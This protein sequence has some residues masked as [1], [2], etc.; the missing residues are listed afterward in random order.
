[1]RVGTG[2]TVSQIIR[3]LLVENQTIVRA[4]LRLILESQAGLNVVAEASTGAEAVAAAEQSQPDVVLLDLDTDGEIGYNC[5]IE[6][7]RA[8]PQTRVLV[9]TGVED[10]EIHYEAIYNGA[11]GLVHKLEQADVLLR[12]IRKVYADEVWLDGAMMARLLQ[13]LRRV[14][15]IQQTT[16]DQPAELWNNGNGHEKPPRHGREDQPRS[17]SPQTTPEEAVKIAQLTDRE[18]EV[19]ALVGEGLRNQQI[20]DRLFISVITVRH[21]ISSVFSKLEVKDR[22][23]LAIYAYRHGLARLPF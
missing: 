9:L 22:F 15:S 12:A 17:F 20:A 14:R 1:M 16:M 6:I 21:H 2:G 18:R 5:L 10:L 8:V 23:E 4:G 19:V 11:M 13:D 3:I 7:L